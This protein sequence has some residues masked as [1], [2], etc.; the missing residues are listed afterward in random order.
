MPLQ[1]ENIDWEV[2]N[3]FVVEP[4]VEEQSKGMQQSCSFIVTIAPT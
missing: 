3:R 1:N 2:W 4:Q